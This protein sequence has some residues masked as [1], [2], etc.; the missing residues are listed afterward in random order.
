MPNEEQHKRGI[1]L[2]EQEKAT[3]APGKSW[4]FGIGINEYDD[5]PKLYNAVKDVKDV[6]TLLSTQY[7]ID[8]DATI[9]LINEEAT[10][11]NIIDQLDELSHKVQPSD[12]LIIYY[13]GHGHVDERTDISYWIPF[14]GKKGKSARHI[15]SSTIRDYVKG[16]PTR[17]TL[18]ISDSCFSGALFVRG[19][20]RSTVALEELETRKSRWALCSGR[21]DEFVYD[22]EP[23]TNSPFAASILNILGTNVSPKLNIA[24]LADRVVELTRSNYQQL[25]EG[26]PLFGVGHEGGQYVFSQPLTEEAA[27]KATKKS[28][29]KAAVLQF[30]HQYPDSIFEAQAR[31]K[32]ALLEE[33]EAWLTA[34]KEGTIEAYMEYDMAYPNGQYTR[35]AIRAIAELEEEKEWTNAIER[36]KISDFRTYLLNY[37]KGAYVEMA[38][39]RIEILMSAHDESVA[40]KAAI[41]EKAETPPPPPTK[42]RAPQ[43]REPR[44]VF[45]IV[46]KVGITV[47]AIIGLSSIILF[48]LDYDFTKPAPAPVNENAP[49]F[50][51][52]D[53][54]FYKGMEGAIRENPVE[55]EV[56]EAPAVQPILPPTI[57]IA[58]GQ[59]TMG[60]ME[61]RDG[62]R[63]ENAL[64]IRVVRLDAFYMSKYEVTNEAFA[65]FLNAKET[66]HRAARNIMK[67]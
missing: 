54:D 18:I 31:E 13:S 49:Q 28:D 58:A 67:R 43:K 11:E 4:F 6:Q 23:G 63:I 17:H 57:P 56:E 55:A 34:L 3:D 5:F 14:D 16:I 8:P 1:K 21:H 12:K 53:E 45:S 52:N 38:Q 35:L 27:W 24:K 48:V 33:E 50:I 40:E 66:W 2:R 41:D 59:F 29:T 61:D 64:P 46:K 26:N 36:D 37:P 19:V 44:S 7:D 51:L 32:L 22:G 60:Y 42:E 39:R 62:E 47:L 15:R 65:L 10:R 20:Q 30:L 9:L 25:P